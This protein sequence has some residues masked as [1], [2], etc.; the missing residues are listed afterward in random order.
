MR[1]LD[2]T[3]PAKQLPP[4][5]KLAKWVPIIV[6]P[7]LGIDERASGVKLANMRRQGSGAGKEGPVRIRFGA[8][9]DEHKAQITLDHLATGPE[10]ARRARSMTDHLGHGRLDPEHARL[11]WVA[12]DAH[13]PCVDC[14]EIAM[15]REAQQPKKGAA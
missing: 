2:K 11:E 14:L 7:S 9:C 6:I 4:G 8:C 13:T 15:E 10:I 12:A 1:R 3:D 5:V